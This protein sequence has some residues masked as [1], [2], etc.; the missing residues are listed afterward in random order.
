MRN[1]VIILALIILG[2]AGAQA[3]PDI[4]IYA[5]ADDEGSNTSKL[6]R[7][8]KEKLP[9]VKMGFVF[10]AHIDRLSSE[11]VHKDMTKNRV[12]GS[13]GF[14]I[15]L[16]LKAMSPN[17]YLSTGFN[18][19]SLSARVKGEGSESYSVNEK[20][21]EVNGQHEH[22][23]RAKYFDV[24]LMIHLETGRAN[25]KF[26]LFG[27]IG[28]AVGWMM[29]CKAN[30]THSPAN[31]SSPD[32]FMVDMRDDM[33][34]FRTDFVVGGGLGLPLDGQSMLT[35]NIR[36]NYGLTNLTNT[37]SPAIPEYKQGSV[38]YLSFGCGILF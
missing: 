3:Q 14:I 13:W 12:D 11:V 29:K 37:N 4:N 22:S 34:R 35:F 17:Y 32:E 16:Q 10:A 18:I 30:T 2:L 27:D 25:R 5:S 33:N 7:K 6:D 31:D 24:P 36:Y 28:F 8:K 15:N 19:N 21:I 9:P 1:L 20:T 23:L 26:S 38:N